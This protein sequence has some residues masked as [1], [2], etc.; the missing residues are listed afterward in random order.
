MPIGYPRAPRK[1]EWNGSGMTIK[2][3][4]GPSEANVNLIAAAPEMMQTLEDILSII[5]TDGQASWGDTPEDGS[6]ITYEIH[7][8]DTI[9]EDIKSVIVKV[10]GVAKCQ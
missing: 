4:Q 2:R 8:I 6:F 5:E 9:K 3:D 10:L 7:H 1:Q